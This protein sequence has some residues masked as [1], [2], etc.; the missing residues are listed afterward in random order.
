V[1]ASGRAATPT[2]AFPAFSFE[3][4]NAGLHQKANRRAS[5]SAGATKPSDWVGTCVYM[6]CD[7]SQDKLFQRARVLTR[8]HTS[9]YVSIRQHTSAYV[10]IRRFDS[11]RLGVYMCLYMC[12]DRAQG[13]LFQCPIYKYIRRIEVLLSQQRGAKPLHREASQ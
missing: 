13:K 12:C 11:F 2:L 9:A 5:Q 10:S 6:C 1:L 7:T 3:A 4:L 8:Q